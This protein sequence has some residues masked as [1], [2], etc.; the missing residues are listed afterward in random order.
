MDNVNYKNLQKLYD[1]IHK[2]PEDRLD[3]KV[4]SSAGYL[5]A[6]YD[7]KAHTCNTNCCLIGWSPH[8]TDLEV[9][10]NDISWINYKNKVFGSNYYLFKFLFS[11]HWEDSIE[12]AKKRIR[13]VLEHKSV[14]KDMEKWLK[15]NN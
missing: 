8:I 10:K 12:L 4:Y 13:Y 6:I 5:Q 2:I 7:F 9:T 3:M 1:N 11:Q 15:E 14:P